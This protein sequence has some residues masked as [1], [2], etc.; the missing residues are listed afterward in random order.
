M[1]YSPGHDFASAVTRTFAASRVCAVSTKRGLPSPR[2]LRMQKGRPN[3][4]PNGT[5]YRGQWGDYR[6]NLVCWIA[7]QSCVFMPG[8]V[9]QQRNFFGTCGTKNYNWASRNEVVTSE[10][11]QP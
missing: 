2:N 6:I 11:A 8:T 3:Q 9:L 5:I 7:A 1:T 10:T 4:T